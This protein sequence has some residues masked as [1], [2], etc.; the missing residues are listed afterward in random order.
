MTVIKDIYGV[1]I[2]DKFIR[3]E[4]IQQRLLELRDSGVE[5]VRFIQ[6]LNCLNL[7]EFGLYLMMFNP[8][9]ESFTQAIENDRRLKLDDLEELYNAFPSCIALDVDFNTEQAKIQM[10]LQLM[11]L[12]IER[13][14]T[15]SEATLDSDAVF[16]ALFADIYPR[17]STFLDTIRSTM[18]SQRSSSLAND[19][20][21][22]SSWFDF[23]E[24]MASWIREIWAVICGDEFPLGLAVGSSILQEAAEVDDEGLQASTDTN[25]YQIADM[26]TSGDMDIDYDFI[27]E[28]ETIPSR[29]AVEYE[30][31]RSGERQAL[32]R[33]DG[34][35]DRVNRAR[36]L[37]PQSDRIKVKFE[38]QDSPTSDSAGNQLARS[39][40]MI[41]SARAHDEIYERSFQSKRMR[42]D[43]RTGLEPPT[44]DGFESRLRIR[45]RT[46]SSE[47]L[48]EEI[49]DRR[50]R[51]NIGHHAVSKA[52]HVSVRWNMDME[53]ALKK[54]VLKYGPQWSQISR[55]AQS[56]KHGE[57]LIKPRFNE[58]KLLYGINNTALKDK[59]RN[60]VIMMIRLGISPPDYLRPVTIPKKYKEAL[61]DIDA[62]T[63]SDML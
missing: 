63:A 11:I 48:S 41:E 38:S 60:I 1:S 52:R 27:N 37:D 35:H 61:M 9:G 6:I 54:A 5:T 59:A 39:N 30:Q 55:E 24:F 2:Q 31:Q 17:D 20:E 25:M 21:K 16:N 49:T 46:S 50:V 8:Y 23:L 33:T 62:R 3:L 51:A 28:H 7:C 56:V 36:L 34:G 19:L 18:R 22:L 57:P 43:I 44:D 40:L 32:E 26:R 10:G 58:L 45:Q 15:G 42:R 47:S 12:L 4:V 14:E 13:S 53:E 29:L